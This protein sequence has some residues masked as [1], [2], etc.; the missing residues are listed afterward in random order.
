MRI[1]KKYESFNKIIKESYFD[2]VPDPE[3]MSVNEWDKEVNYAK[4]IA[5]TQK[6][7]NYS[8]L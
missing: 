2:E 6:K 8:L 1:L 7:K 5:F 3:P 4:E